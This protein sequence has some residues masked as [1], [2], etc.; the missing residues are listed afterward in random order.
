MRILPFIGVI[1]FTLI[2]A[3][4]NFT[5][6]TECGKCHETIYQ[7]WLTSMHARA[8]VQ[9]DPLYRGMYELAVEESQGKLE[10]KCIVCHSPMSTVFGD[11][12]RELEYNQDGVSC[13]FCHGAA[14]ITSFISAGDI[15]IELDTVYSANPKPDNP[16]H[17]VAHRDYYRS[18]ELCL[19]CHAEMKNP[20]GLKVCATGDEWQ[21]YHQKTG[22]T[23]LD[24]HMPVIDGVAA[25]SFFGSHN[26][27][28]ETNAVDMDLNYSPEAAQLKI[29]LVNSGAGHAI[30]TGTPLRMVILKV[31]AFDSS[32]RVV[33]ENWREN[34]LLEDK[35][36]LFMKIMGDE[37]GNS[38]VPPWK[39]TRTVFEQR[40]MPG[41]PV[42]LTYPLDIQYL[43]DIE[44][45]LLFRFAPPAL[46]KRF[47]IIDT[48][49]TRER[50]LAQKAM[51]ISTTFR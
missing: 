14:H 8:T 16:A 40:L 4:E 41:V 15:A 31:T 30:P 11:I 27:A 26:Y 44:A 9:K 43:Y 1:I 3:Q 39:A 25:H 37:E 32:G 10:S 33:W 18:G 22:K 48:H 21:E 5:R 17:P 24:C 34:P 42:T 6:A 46:L 50:I 28:R 2:Q 12:N 36:S 38:P 7:D 19:P 20:R 35:Q 49:F 29:T 51:V 45:R 47:N 13:Q 23:C